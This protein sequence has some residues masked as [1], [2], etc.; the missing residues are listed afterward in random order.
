[1]PPLVNPQPL[2]GISPGI[3]LY[4]PC[5]PLGVLLYLFLEVAGAHRRYFFL[6]A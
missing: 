3:F 4:D 1:M 5:I 2:V 6:E